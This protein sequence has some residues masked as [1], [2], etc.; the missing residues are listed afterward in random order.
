MAPMSE[1]R[2][3]RRPAYVPDLEGIAG[4]A[5]DARSVVAHRTAQAVLAAGRASGADG[6]GTQRQRLLDLAGHVGVDD[7]AEL[8]RDSPADSLPG[9]LW[10]LYLLRTWVREDGEQAARLYAAGRRSAEV[11]DVVAGVAGVPGPGEV[12]AL[13]DAVLT[14]AFDGELADA[15]ERA[16]AFARVVAAGRAHEDAGEQHR[17]GMGNLRLAERLERA[18]RLWRAGRLE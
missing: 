9:A 15:L 8:W 18:A 12:A 2:A 6:A 7:L 5:P 17:L 3:P 4:P 14:C 10:G 11:A 1:P 13:G 16:A